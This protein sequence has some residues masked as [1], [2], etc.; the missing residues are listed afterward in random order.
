METQT[1]PT[2]GFWAILELFGHTKLAGHV[3]EYQFGGTNFIRVDVPETKTQPSF[4]K[5]LNHGAVYA[6]T[7]VDEQL[8]RLQAENISARP[9]E[10]YELSRMLEKKLQNEGLRLAIVYPDGQIE[11]SKAQHNEDE[12]GANDDDELSF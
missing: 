5:I 10:S 2:P 3:T 4:S 9:L 12:Y 6:I 8:S 1:T 7:P 11:N